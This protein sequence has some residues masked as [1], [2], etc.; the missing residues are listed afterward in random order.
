MKKFIPLAIFAVAL[1]VTVFAC[2]TAGPSPQQLEEQERARQEAK[3]ARSDSLEQEVRIAW[4]LGM[5]YYKNTQYAD[6]IRY[7]KQMVEELDPMDNRGWRYLADS[8]FRM[9]EHDSAFAVYAEGIQRFPEIAFLHRG[10]AMLYQRKAAEGQPEL[11]DSAIASYIIAYELDNTDAYSPTQIGMVL[12]SRGMLDSSLVWFTRSVEADPNQT[13][14]W[15]KMADLYLVRGNWEGV[16]EAYR[17]LA[18]IDPTNTE[19]A[20]NLG[21]A[22]A[23][24]GD[25]EDAVA[26]LE[27][28]IVSNPE[29]YRGYQ[30]MGLV[31]AAKE[32]YDLAQRSFIDAEKLAP[33]NVRLLLDIA[34]TYIQMKRFD[35]ATQYLNKARQQDRN[36]CQAI[37]VEGD[38]CV[39]RAR[40]AVPEEGVGVREK[41]RFECCYEIYSRAVNR[42]DCDRWGDVAR[43]KMRYLDQFLPTAQ[44]KTEFFF[45]HPDLEGKICD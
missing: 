2:A 18:R 32:R 33:T 6:A 19:Y 43:M 7:F 29:D 13:D 22:Q 25:Y 40:A 42:G 9:G 24:T 20:L 26:T 4:S 31:H 23:N 5:E 14:T 16:R 41:L 28:Y 1:L 30:Y 8:Y 11:L 36:S 21:R 27:A 38:I 37:V 34:D 44:E 12:L 35:Q 15:L 10:L 17:N 3:E 45:I 39:G